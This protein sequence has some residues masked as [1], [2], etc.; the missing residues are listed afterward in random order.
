MSNGFEKQEKTVRRS[1]AHNDQE[2]TSLKNETLPNSLV[3]RIMQ[4][5]G[6]EAEADRLSEGVTS[7]SP[8]TLRREMGER[9]GADFS[10]VHFHSD[11]NSVQQSEAIGARAW[12]QGHDVYFGKGGFN[13]SVAA[14]ELV[15]TVQQGAVRGNVSRSASFGSVQMKPK[16][17]DDPKFKAKAGSFVQAEDEEPLPGDSGDLTAIEAQA[18]QTFE[19]SRG[20]AVYNAIMPDLA[21][22]V[23]KAGANREDAKIRF[24]P[25]PALSFLIRAAY[26]DYALRDILVELVNKGIGLWKTG[27][28]TKQYKALI[29]SVSDRLGEYQAEELAIQTGML[30]DIEHPE[31]NGKKTRKVNKRAYDL[32]PEDKNTDSFNPGNIP[33]IAKIQ[34]EIDAA[35]T[36]EKA[37]GIFAKFTGNKNAKVLK[38]EA[39]EKENIEYQVNLTLT[40]NKL[41]NMARQVWDY[42]ELRNNI[43]NLKLYDSKEAAKM[44][45]MSTH[46]GHRKT[47]IFYNSYYDREGMEA[48]IKRGA[49]RYLKTKNTLV[50]VDSDHS[51]NHELGHVLGSSLVSPGA[52]ASQAEQENEIKKT[53]NSILKE[54][55]LNQNILSD[56]QKNG[57]RIYND[58]GFSYRDHAGNVIP[59][60]K[61]NPILERRR[62][63]I[64]EGKKKNTDPIP[65]IYDRKKYYKGQINTAGSPTLDDRNI[66]SAYGRCS[67]TE[68]F[69]ETFGDVYQHGKSAKPVSIATVREY[70]RR[71]KE[72]QKMKYKYNQSNWFMK[73][74][75]KKVKTDDELNTW[76][77]SGVRNARPVNAAANQAPQIAN[78]NP[79]AAQNAV[80]ANPA[81][82]AAE[83]EPAVQIANPN[84]FDA[85][86]EI[87]EENPLNKSMIVE[88]PKTRKNK[89]KKKRF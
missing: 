58:E 9:L 35:D 42:P 18:M 43:G 74:F 47:P 41:K 28:R 56:E 20:H 70:E 53:E 57:I 25:K 23:K 26:Q 24:R 82:Q 7:T 6:A 54:V 1:A 19:S 48:E 45:V 73:L 29:K 85:L 38:T 88:N 68:M 65:E 81:A 34:A 75:R 16:G 79:P 36:L 50:Y 69:A 66:T 14:H 17:L 30:T 40:K 61:V 77:G 64:R 49:D 32:S 71:Q 84:P 2:R 10:G 46:G 52:N 87:E 44:S 31:Y 55:L 59:M 63:E 12:T 76:T 11:T 22:M 72:L 60:D 51:G 89:K 78:V 37:Y 21:E 39:A 4:D 83:Q 27:T 86:P 5:P 62:Q 80:N 15:H 8:A 33:E 3:S 67:P 13:P